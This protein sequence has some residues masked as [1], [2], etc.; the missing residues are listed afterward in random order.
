M[1]FKLNITDDVSVFQGPRGPRGDDGGRG[2]KGDAGEPGRPGPPG[3]ASQNDPATIIAVRTTAVPVFL[4]LR[5]LRN[6]ADT[7][8]DTT[9]T[10]F[11][12]HIPLL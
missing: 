10:P 3:D 2:E 9:E 8:T 1:F 6:L 7:C 5:T 12:W 11:A 4:M